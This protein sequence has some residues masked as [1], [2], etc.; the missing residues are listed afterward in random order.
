[1]AVDLAPTAIFPS[2]SFDGTTIT[3]DRTDLFELTAAA[4]DPAL[5]DARAVTL[6]IL[7]T[8]YKRYLEM[9]EK[10]LAVVARYDPGQFVTYGDFFETIRAQ[11]RL[12]FYVRFPE[13][14]IVDEPA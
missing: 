13:E 2:W 11:F 1:M 8:M 6:A 10:P 4:C 14:T 12:A 3:L 7:K 5:G 9:A